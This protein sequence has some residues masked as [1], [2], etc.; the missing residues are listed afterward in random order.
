MNKQPMRSMRDY[1]AR[2]HPDGSCQQSMAIGFHATRIESD[3]GM[4]GYHITLEGEW[5][6]CEHSANCEGGCWMREIIATSLGS[7]EL[8]NVP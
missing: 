7:D 3:C 4:K 5:R 6:C 8:R 1:V 2:Y